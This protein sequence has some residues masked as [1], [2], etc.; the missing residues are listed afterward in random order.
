MYSRLA[1]ESVHAN[2]IPIRDDSILIKKAAVLLTSNELAMHHTMA[3]ARV[4]R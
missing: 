2:G 1:A 3:A 4:L